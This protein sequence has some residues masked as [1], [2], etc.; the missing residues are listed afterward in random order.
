MKPN[1]KCII[2]K[3]PIYIL[4][5]RLENKF[6]HACSKQCRS[7]LFS[8][9]RVGKNNPTYGRIGEKSSNYKNGKTKNQKGYILVLSNNHPFKDKNNYVYEHRLV[10]ENNYL[11]FD[12]KYFIEIDGKFYLKKEVIVHHIN[13]NKSDNRIQN[14]TLYTKSE[15]QK[16]HTSENV[17]KLI[18]DNK[19]R[20]IKQ[21]KTL[22]DENR[23]S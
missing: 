10:I 20:F 17:T 1:C 21:E 6:G 9:Y 18:R 19:G 8:K 5:C 2:C 3:K 16:L 23:Y 11:N 12:A 14:L 13:E 4:P 15:H 7:E 22:E